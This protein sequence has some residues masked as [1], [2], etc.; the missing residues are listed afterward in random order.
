MAISPIPYLPKD[1]VLLIEDATGT[2][3]AHTVAYEDGDFGGVVF[4]QSD[5]G[6][7]PFLDR[8]AHYA[9]RLGD[10]EASPFTFSATATELADAT[11]SC[12]IDA[13]TGAGAFSAGVSTWGANE[14]VWTVKITWTGDT[15]AIGGDASTIVLT[16][17]RASVT[18][19]EGSP[20][21]FTVS[22]MAFLK[23]GA[24]IA[25]T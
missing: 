24:G 14:E 7:L 25:R 17:C 21:K 10:E 4:Q 9:L 11:E 2:P 22:G 12:L 19:A 6:V 3:I 13:I 1:G 16:Y 15:S 18:F 8:G 5:R 20:G 23:A